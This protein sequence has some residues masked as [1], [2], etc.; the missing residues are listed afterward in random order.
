MRHNNIPA[1]NSLINQSTNAFHPENPRQSF[2]YLEQEF[3]SNSINNFIENQ[4]IMDLP[5]L[6]SPTNP[7]T[8]EAAVDQQ[9]SG[10][11]VADQNNDHES[12]ST[13]NIK[14]EILDNLLDSEY[15]PEPTSSSFSNHHDY[16][17]DPHD[18]MG[19]FLGSFPNL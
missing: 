12:G 8:K 15:L 17:L 18:Q 7:S 3:T 19:S 5:R 6:D 2:G 9:Q 13:N 4:L 16:E 11:I 14:W 10:L 1:H